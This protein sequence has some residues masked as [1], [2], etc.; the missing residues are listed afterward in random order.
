MAK[1]QDY[2]LKVSEFKLQFHYR[3]HFQTNTLAKV[4]NYLIPLNT[5]RLNSS[6]DVFLQGWLWH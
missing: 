6:A 2:Y 5:Y 3:I 4:M 1:M